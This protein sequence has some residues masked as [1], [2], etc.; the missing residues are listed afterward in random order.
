MH[1]LGHRHYYRELLMFIAFL[2]I[3]LYSTSST[4]KL[5]DSLGYRKRSYLSITTRIINYLINYVIGVNSV[6]LEFN[7]TLYKAFPNAVVA[8]CVKKLLYRPK[9][10]MAV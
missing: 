5:N 7:V 2:I 9:C 8:P 10:H 1:F 3:N 6:R 4:I